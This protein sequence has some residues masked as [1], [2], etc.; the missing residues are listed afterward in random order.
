MGFP[1]IAAAFI[2]E[3]FMQMYYH[4]PVIRVSSNSYGI[5]D[6]TLGVK[7]EPLSS[8]S[9]AY[10][11]KKG[12]V[13]DC[14]KNLSVTNK[15]GFRGIDTIAD[16]REAK[17]K[18]L[19]SGASFSHWNNEGKTIVDYTK[20]NLQE[21]IP[22][23]SVLNVAGGTFSL[24]HMIVNIS[25]TIQNKAINK[26]DIVVIQFSR[27]DLS[28]GWWYAD[29]LKDEHGYTRS[30]I[31]KSPRCLKLN[32]NCGTDEYLINPKATYEWCVGQKGKKNVDVVGENLIAQY[33]DIKGFNFIYL[34]RLLSNYYSFKNTKNIPVV[35][36]PKDIDASK[37]ETATD[38]FKKSDIKILFILLPNENEIKNK[39]VTLP[40]YT[41]RLI[42]FYESKLQS[43]V[44]MPSHFSDFD[45]IDR[46]AVSKAD[47]HPSVEAQKAYGKYIANIILNAN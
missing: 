9:F 21:V 27:S 38:F 16:F 8:I 22:S 44:I 13:L 14:I 42:N 24:S 12:E 11:N 33:N 45:G 18:V 36:F 23:V 17:L 39:K 46:F 29:A 20:Q 4:Q 28:R 5:Y 32:S 10:L 26:P 35:T 41:K 31:A 1:T 7:Y 6:K 15:D 2:Y 3:V 19:V 47:R 25:Q 40:K 34:P 37:L 43:K 30:R